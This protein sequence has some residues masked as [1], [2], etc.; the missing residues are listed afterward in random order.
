MGMVVLG[1]ILLLLLLTVKNQTKLDPLFYGSTQS[2]TLQQGTKQYYSCLL[3]RYSACMCVSSV[4][5]VFLHLH[6]G[7]DQRSGA[8]RLHLRLHG[9]LHSAGEMIRAP[10]KLTSTPKSPPTVPLLTPHLRLQ[11]EPHL[12]SAYGVMMSYWEG[13]VHLA[14]FL[15]IIHRMFN[16]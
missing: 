7:P 3:T 14:L 16:G 13:V 9:L 4:C 11:G 6:G 12:S 15:T 2:N 8:E 10:L 5:R 1:G